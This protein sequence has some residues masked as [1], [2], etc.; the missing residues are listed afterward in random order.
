LRERSVNARRNVL[1]WARSKLSG[2]SFGRRPVLMG[3]VILRL[4]GRATFGAR[5]CADA[6]IAA[7]SF[8]VAEDA[9][10]SVGDD[11]FVMAGTCV[12]AWHEVRI[13]SHAL[14]A[15]NVSIIDD[16]R[17]HV[18]PVSARYKGPVV[19]CDNVWLGRNVAVMPGVTIGNGSAIGANSVVT[20]DI[21]PAVF[22][23]GSPARVLRKLDLPEGWVRV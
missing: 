22:A 8:F 4:A 5:F 13:G 6:R 19:I 18:E 3:R 1:G 14:I 20:Q 17:H 2:A 16:A 23:A 10:L 15:S 9:V 11:V 12:E 7:V 21:P